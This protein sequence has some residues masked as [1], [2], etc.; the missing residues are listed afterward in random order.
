V[1]HSIANKQRCAVVIL[2]LSQ[3]LILSEGYHEKPQASSD[4]LLT[5]SSRVTDGITIEP[6]RVVYWI[7]PPTI[8]YS[9]NNNVLHLLI[10]LHSN[11]D[12]LLNN[13]APPSDWS[14]RALYNF[15]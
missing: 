3:G 5:G 12:Y 7:Y 6:A 2:I 10:I 15:P 1:R 11:E 8:I 13:G 14:E 9:I 4:V